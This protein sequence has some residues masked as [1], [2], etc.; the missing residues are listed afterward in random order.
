MEYIPEISYICPSKRKDDKKMNIQDT[1][2]RFY[3]RIEKTCFQGQNLRKVI[4]MDESERREYLLAQTERLLSERPRAQVAVWLSDQF[5]TADEGRIPMSGYNPLLDPGARTMMDDE[6]RM[7]CAFLLDISGLCHD[8]FCHFPF[9]LSVLGIETSDEDFYASNAALV[10]W[11]LAGRYPHIGAHV[12]HTMK[13]CTLAL[14]TPRYQPAQDYLAEMR[15]QS[16][17]ILGVSDVKEGD[18]T[19]F[20]TEMLDGLRLLDNHLSEGFDMGLKLEE[21]IYHDELMGRLFDA[22]GYIDW[23]VPLARELYQT[24]EEMYRKLDICVPDLGTQVQ[25]QPGQEAIGK[26]EETII[27][28]AREMREREGLKGWFEDGS[29]AMGYLLEH[30]HMKCYGMYD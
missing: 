17:G 27:G 1:I 14:V 25:P 28:K 30:S 10:D 4:T 23:L 12:A 20:V 11:L 21:I 29:L 9:D 15:G 18:E 26:M 16:F 24:A 2:E 5:W 6:Q 19:L 22:D 7:L 13:K 8:L 3:N